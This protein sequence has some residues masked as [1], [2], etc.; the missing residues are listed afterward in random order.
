MSTEII[1][2]GDFVLNYGGYQIRRDQNASRPGPWDLYVLDTDGQDVH[3]QQYFPDYVA[4]LPGEPQRY[5][6][7]QALGL[8]LRWI[9]ENPMAKNKAPFW[10][11]GNGICTNPEEVI[12]FDKGLYRCLIDLASH[13]DTWLF[14]YTLQ[15]GKSHYGGRAITL[16]KYLPRYNSREEA[17]SAGLELAAGWFTE[18]KP[19]N[20]EAQDFQIR[21]L[22]LIDASASQIKSDMTK[23]KNTS[24]PPVEGIGGK[25]TSS[26]DGP[27]PE[28][29]HVQ[30]GQIS[31]DP[32]QPRKHFNPIDDKELL[33]SIKSQ[34]I[35]QSLLIRP[36]TSSEAL[37]GDKNIKTEFVIVCGERRYRAALEVLKEDPKWMGGFLP[38][39][40][41][42]MN[43]EEAKEAQIVENLQRKEVHP[44]EEALAF[45]YL[46]K[47][48]LTQEQIGARVGKGDRFVRARIVLCNLIKS[49]Q[50]LFL[51]QAIDL[52]TALKI[53]RYSTDLQTRILN[54]Q[55]ISKK[56]MEDPGL[57]VAVKDFSAYRGDL[58]SAC[59]DTQDPNLITKMGACDSCPFNSANGSLFPEDTAR[60]RCMN[61][62]C[63]QE[64]T[65]A[66]FELKLEEARKN[67]EVVLL[68]AGYRQDDDKLVKTLKGQG[69]VVLD[70]GA[71]REVEIPC[72]G[73]YEEWV[74]KGWDYEGQNNYEHEDGEAENRKAYAREVEHV[75]KMDR[76]LKSGLKSGKYKMA[77]VVLGDHEHGRG[78][79][80]PVEVI[81]TKKGGSDAG[82]AVKAKPAE[83]IKAG[84]AS[85]NDYMSEIQRLTKDIEDTKRRN[86]FQVTDAIREAFKVHPVNV[87]QPVVLM[88]PERAAL[89]FFMLE[90]MDGGFREL[91]WW[92]DT[93]EPTG[94]EQFAKALGVPA[95]KNKRPKEGVQDDRHYWHLDENKEFD[96]DSEKTR[97]KVWQWI[98]DLTDEKFGLIARRFLFKNFKQFQADDTRSWALMQ[99]IEC[100]AGTQPGEINTA[101]IKAEISERNNKRVVNAQER[102]KM[103]KAGKKQLEDKKASKAVAKK[104][105]TDGAEKKPAAKATGK[106]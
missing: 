76:D 75:A 29:R 104:V 45:E 8:V 15:C 6:Y 93:K 12:L 65:N 27:A 36:K 96:I 56:D 82:E 21:I 11:D 88:K 44:L 43:D 102:I 55:K 39:Q 61:L 66:G 83:K 34:G 53:C 24:L 54:D 30:I 38:V 26:P 92:K 71:Y 1:F 95:S 23:T 3:Q 40:I 49:W 33:E 31:P 19:D 77:L 103:L 22:S 50:D 28:S 62:G 79:M 97:A 60:P 32:N 51:R 106:K 87:S 18:V 86:E 42:H 84:K 70:H 91:Q 85:V 90:E 58:L 10:F 101:A 59:F 94:K 4:S 46:T 74:A 41:R 25:L 2:K 72:L 98:Q 69:L 73:S 89:I 37:Q 63:F 7:S 99:L 47:K 20:H 100:W 13:G 105:A 68:K 5:D 81:A 17:L 52:E 64:K 9:D 35:L 16:D 78:K 57:R 14:G 48:G 80:V 67:P